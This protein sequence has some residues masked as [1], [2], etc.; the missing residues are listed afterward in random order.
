MEVARHRRDVRSS[1][2][3][4][5]SSIS[6]QLS[7]CG[8]AA[9]SSFEKMPGNSS[10]RHVAV[11]SPASR[12]RPAAVGCPALVQRALRQQRELGSQL[13]DDVF[14]ARQHRV[15]LRRTLLRS[16][17]LRVTAVVDGVPFGVVREGGHGFGLSLG[18]EVLLVTA[19]CEGGYRW[20]ICVVRCLAL[21]REPLERGLRPRAVR[22]FFI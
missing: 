13:A 12:R 10:R 16:V 11:K 18:W 22:W 17:A 7:T 14:R 8:H 20:R 1:T 6:A 19:L 21:V 2:L 15:L 4:E 9:S 5:G 3:F